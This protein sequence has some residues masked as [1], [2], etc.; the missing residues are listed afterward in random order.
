MNTTAESTDKKAQ[1]YH[2]FSN[3]RDTQVFQVILKV[4]CE[5]EGFIKL[6]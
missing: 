1:F 5:Q 2:M 4:I 3:V 6:E